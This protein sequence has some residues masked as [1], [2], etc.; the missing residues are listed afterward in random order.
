ME[1]LLNDVKKLVREEQTRASDSHGSRHH[2]LHEAYGVIKEELVEAYDCIEKAHQLLEEEFFFCV[3]NDD[4]MHSIDVAKQ[5]YGAASYLA[6]E[7]IQVAAMAKKAAL[8]PA[9]PS[10][11]KEEEKSE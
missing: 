6:A 5:L 11:K 3:M 4:D 2:S 9:V 10:N 1:Q 7:A 8:G